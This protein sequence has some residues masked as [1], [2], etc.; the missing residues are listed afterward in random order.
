MDEVRFYHFLQAMPRPIEEKKEYVDPRSKE[1]IVNDRAKCAKI[2]E[3]GEKILP[4]NI[5]KYEGSIR[6]YKKRSG[7]ERWLTSWASYSFV[8]S[9][10]HDTEEKAIQYKRD[11]CEREGLIKNM[12]YKHNDEY[13]C[14]LSGHIEDQMMKFSSED[15]DIIENTIWTSYYQPRVKACYASTSIKG[16]WRSF[17]QMVFPDMKPGETGDHFSRDTLDNSRTNLRVA[18]KSIQTINQRERNSSNKSGVK[19]VYFDKA[20]NRWRA[21][22][23][24]D[25]GKVIRESFYVTKTFSYEDAFKAA[26]VAR[27]KAKSRIQKYI[28][29]ATP[30]VYQNN[31]M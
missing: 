24:E 17:A 23:T 30:P 19:G 28:D 9:K 1:Q 20:G 2:M 4:S 6:K 5:D 14:L 25:N 18:S 13:Y 11:I 31:T 12:I 29:A 3:E 22:W 15:I 27:N 10:T 26:V 7:G 21:K 8:H 16:K